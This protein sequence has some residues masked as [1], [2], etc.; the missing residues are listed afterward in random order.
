MPVVRCPEANCGFATADVGDAVG[1]VLLTHHLNGAHRGN[2][3]GAAAAQAGNVKK[4]DRPAMKEDAN[5]QE[6]VTFEFEWDRY[7]KAAGIAADNDKI[8]SELLYSC[9]STLRARLLEMVGKD[10]LDTINEADLLKLIKRSAVLTVEKVVHRVKFHEIKQE[11]GKSF[12]RFVPR[13]KA[14]AN[15]CEFTVQGTYKCSNG[16]AKDIDMNLRVSYRDD[17]VESQMIAGLYNPEHRSK[18][19]MEADKLTSFDDKYKALATMHATD[20]STGELDS[21]R[22]NARR[23]DYKQE[24]NQRKCDCGKSIQSKNQQHTKCM[25]CHK[26]DW[27]KCSCG[28]LKPPGRAKCRKCSTAKP[29]NPKESKETKVESD[30]EESKHTTASESFLSGGDSCSFDTVSDTVPDLNQKTV[31]GKKHRSSAKPARERK[32]RNKEKSDTSSHSADTKYDTE[33]DLILKGMVSGER[34]EQ[35]QFAKELRRENANFAKS[36]GVRLKNRN[37][38]V[39]NLEWV[40]GQFI[41]KAP[42][43]QPHAHVRATIMDESMRRFGSSI[44]KRKA[45]KW[46]TASGLTDTGAQTCS[47]GPAFLEALGCKPEEMLTTSHGIR[48]ICNV[49]LAL[50][51]AVL[52]KLE[53]NGLTARAMVY[54]SKEETGLLLSQTVLKML[55]FIKEDFP[56]KE[57][58][59]SSSAKGCHCPKRAVTP[60]LP[61]QLPCPATEENRAQLERF[62]KDH[63]KASAFNTCEHQPLQAMTGPPLDIVFKEG[64][65]PVAVHTPIPVAYHWK[66]QVKAELDRDV[67]LGIIEEVPAGTPTK[68]C[69][70]M[71]VAPKQ[72]TGKPRR[73][74]DLQSVNDATYRETHH[75]E[76][77]HQ[78]VSNVPAGQKKTF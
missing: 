69:S 39:P 13:L 26:K 4:P 8:R 57:S 31:S 6:W 61:T 47:A 38:I 40:D 34:K 32:T 14:K 58:M 56:A 44:L 63:Y 23:S 37:V 55:G 20:F 68:W 16:C 51:G 48:G 36:C 65:D 53:A 7:K 2:A 42:E 43:E 59:T 11:E 49:K 24:K 46:A 76:T 22:T 67:K 1:A 64:T 77:P 9:D 19:M 25:A 73:T 45:E 5:D 74:V 10:T 33:P 3:A 72:N 50:L 28:D 27:N 75:T 52:V 54:I 41:P 66:T 78:L 70:R 35:Q 18:I 12:Q 62:I 60:P 29:K 21:T 71:V 15:L 17:M 30:T